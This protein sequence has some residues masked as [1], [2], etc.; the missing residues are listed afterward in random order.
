ML[1]KCSAPSKWAGWDAACL[2][3]QTSSLSP[4]SLPRMLWFQFVSCFQPSQKYISQTF[5]FSSPHLE[6]HSFAS[7]SILAETNPAGIQDTQARRNTSHRKIFIASTFFLNYQD[8]WVF[9]YRTKGSI[10]FQILFCFQGAKK[11]GHAP[12]QL[13]QPQKSSDFNIK[14]LS[15]PPP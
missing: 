5:L 6:K 15:F 1:T 8:K 12:S 11:I 9:T 4:A 2:S 10:V 14:L 7:V 13:I 3:K